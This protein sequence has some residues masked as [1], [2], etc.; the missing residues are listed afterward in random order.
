ME[1]DFIEPNLG[2]A[3]IMGDNLHMECMDAALEGATMARGGAIGYLVAPCHE[4][5]PRGTWQHG[6]GMSTIMRGKTLIPIRTPL[7]KQDMTWG[8]DT[9]A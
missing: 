7:S 1:Q 9:K 8:R 6:N 5:L 4:G 3:N 2:C